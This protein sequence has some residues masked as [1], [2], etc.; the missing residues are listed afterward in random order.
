MINGSNDMFAL[1]YKFS[2]LVNVKLTTI[3]DTPEVIEA[4]KTFGMFG[5]ADFVT[6]W[7]MQLA[8]R[9]T[10]EFNVRNAE[11]T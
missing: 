3:Q 11:I 6:R 7:Y 5:T 8:D 10:G 4:L 1:L 9:V 2:K